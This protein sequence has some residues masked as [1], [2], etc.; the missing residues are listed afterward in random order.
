MAIPKNTLD[1]SVN[2]SLVAV[3]VNHQND[4]LSDN[5]L[6]IDDGCFLIEFHPF[7]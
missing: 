6:I 2:K 4:K 7:R 1:K 5:F 3:F